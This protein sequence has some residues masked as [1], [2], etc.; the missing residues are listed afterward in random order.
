[1]S[2]LVNGEFVDMIWTDPP[3]N[4]DYHGCTQDRMTIANDHLSD[5]DFRHFLVSLFTSC[6]TWAK[7][8]CPIYV[9]Y[10]D[11]E[12]INFRCSL[13]MAGWKLSQTL[14]WMKHQF[15]LSRQDYHWQH[16][17]ILYGWKQGRKHSWQGGH[18]QS[19]MVST[20]P[21]IE[22]MSREQLLKLCK[23]LRNLLPGTVIKARKPLKNKEHPTMKPVALVLRMMMNS[24]V[25]GDT[26]LDPCGGSGSTLI[27]AEKISR[28]ACVMEIDPRYCDV[29]VRRWQDFTGC[30]AVHADTGRCFDDSTREVA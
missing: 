15:I 5:K 7:P 13:D 2:T 6:F 17:P 20:E 1:M 22:E 28:K 27:A 23:S 14:V 24:S 16:E 10:A 19:S 18:V 12:S 26:V 25:R 3:Y 30:K 11:S 4:I 8:G 29:I 21:P 9:A